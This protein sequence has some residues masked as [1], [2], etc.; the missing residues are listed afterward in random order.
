MQKTERVLICD[1]CGEVKDVRSYVFNRNL[2]DRHGNSCQYD[3]C[4]EL[5]PECQDKMYAVI[6]SNKERA[7]AVV[8][9]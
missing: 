7:R 8:T 4:I 6:L 1:V 9:E 3:E 5:C 2:R